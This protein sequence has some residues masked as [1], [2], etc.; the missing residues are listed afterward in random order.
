ME[1]TIDIYWEGA[2]SSFEEV[3]KHIEEDEIGKNTDY[4]FYQIYGDHVTYGKDVLLYIGISGNYKSNGI[5]S[6]LKSHHNNWTN[7]L[8]SEIKIYIG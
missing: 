5:V 3:S 4:F 7:G 1:L 6:R 2:F 8:C